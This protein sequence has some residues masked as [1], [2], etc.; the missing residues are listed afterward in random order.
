DQFEANCLTAAGTAFLQDRNFERALEHLRRAAQ[1][2][3]QPDIEA[4]PTVQTAMLDEVRR[5]FA[6][7]PS[8]DSRAKAS[9]PS[10]SSGFHGLIRR[11][12]HIQAPCREASFWE[13]LCFL[14][15][16]DP[17]RALTALQAAR[18]GDDAAFIDPPLYL[19]AVLLGQ[20][21]AKEALRH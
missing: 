2:R 4:R 19:G 21:K 20:G 1:L 16:H 7:Q 10:A 6:V 11:S 13:G 14:R 3:E 9:H 17:Q 8:H 18:T 15:E 12:L 5:L